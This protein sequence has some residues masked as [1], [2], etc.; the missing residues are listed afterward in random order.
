MTDIAFLSATELAELIANRSISASELLALYLQR[1][2]RFNPALNAIVVQMRDTARAAAARVDRGVTAGSASGLMLGIPMTIKE[3]YNLAGT[4]TTWGNPDWLD[5]IPTDDALAVGKLKA[6]GAIVFGKTNVPLALADFQSYNDIY[7]TTNNPYDLTRTPGGSSGGSAAALAAGLSALE[8]GSD[9]G[10]SIRNPAH[11]CG[12]FGH[13]PTW[14]LLSSYGHSGPGEHRSSRDISVIGPLA[15]SAADLETAVRIMAGP[16]EIMARGYR[17]QLPE[18][19]ATGL[20]GLRIAVWQ[21]DE[22]CPVSAEVRARV[23]QVAQLLADRGALIHWDA[24]PDFSADHSHDT[25]QTLLQ[26][27]MASRMPDAD[28]TRLK[29]YASSLDPN[30][31]GSKAR[32]LRAQ[33]ASFKDWTASNELRHRLRWHWHRFFAE[34]DLLLTPIMPTA[35]FPHD[36]RPP[37]E[38]TVTVDDLQLPY[39]QQL[40]W[41]GLSGVAYLPS[42]VIP[43]GLNDAGLPIGLQLVGPEYGDLVTIGAARLL[44]ADGCRFV[45][46]PAYA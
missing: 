29:Q 35:A 30:D 37:G 40:F 44:E 41:A 5:N 24:R 4:P 12:V 27:A 8:I 34:Y 9:I 22:M 1:I 38:R 7:G 33:V 13:K 42:T 10:G 11:Y 43:T 45:P 16:D 20:R 19:P 2:D 3:S 32:V 39:F 31:S 6:A 26:A 17:L 23:A 46:P 14:N 18:L 15:R 25:F 36:H 28:Y 21:D